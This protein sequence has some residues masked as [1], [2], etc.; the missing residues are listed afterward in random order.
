M[1][2]KNLADDVSVASEDSIR[3]LVRKRA[4][5]KRKITMAL[6]SID[7]DTT[8]LNVNTCKL[9]IEELFKHLV[10]LNDQINDVYLDGE[11]G[12]D[13]EEISD[14][15]S[16][17]LES[18]MNYS[19][20][21]KRKLAN[22][23][24]QYAVNGPV[25]GN[26]QLGAMNDCKLKLPD[27][28]I[29]S[30]NGEG[31]SNMEYHSFITSF[32]NI[33]GLRP[34][35]SDS[36]KF[37]YLKTYVKGYASKIIQ[38]LQTT[39]D[40]Y[41]VALQLLE[42][43][44]LNKEALISDLFNKLIELKPESDKDFIKTK[45]FIN[46]IKCVLSDLKNYGCD[47]VTDE[48]SKS[49][50]SHLVFSRLPFAF[51]QELVR[52]INNNYPSIEDMYD[53]YVEVVKTLNLKFANKSFERTHVPSKPDKDRYAHKS[54][55]DSNNR[56][57]FPQHSINA[58]S[59]S[60]S[61]NNSKPEFKKNCKFCNC[62]SHNMFNCKKFTSHDARL[63]RCRELN[64]CENCTSLKHNKSN[65]KTSLDFGC[66][67]CKSKSHISALCPTF[68]NKTVSN[69]CVNSSRL[70]GINILPTLNI[71]LSIGNNETTVR[72]LVDTGSQ[73]SYISGS[74]ADRLKYNSQ[75][76]TEFMVNTFLDKSF[77]TFSETSLSLSYGNEDPII[78]PFLV[79][80][81][82]DLSFSV[83]GLA[84][85][86]YNIARQYNLSEKLEDD[87]VLVEGVLGTDIIQ[88]LGK[89]EIV[90]CLGGIALKFSNGIVPIGN[91]D[92]FLFNKQLAYKYNNPPIHG[93][94]S[95]NVNATIVNF[96]VEPVKT[97]FDP[98]GCAIMDS[99]VDDRLDNLFKV[100]SLGISEVSCDYDHD[101]ITKF[102]DNISFNGDNYS[103]NLPWHD[104]LL[105][106]VP[107]N[108]SICKSVLNKVVSGLKEKNLYD[109]YDQVFKDQLENDIIE[110]VS[111]DSIDFDK[112]TFIPHRAVIKTDDKCTT[113]LRVVLNC[114]LKIGDKPS[115]NEAAY[116]GVNLMGDLFKLLI[117]VRADDY[118]VISDVKSAFLMIKLQK[119]SDRNHFT[120]LWRNHEGDLVA[121][122][123]KTIVFG[124]V[125][126][127]FILNYL[128][129]FHNAKY[130]PDECSEI[131]D[132]N[133]YVDNLFFTGNEEHM[134]ESMYLKSLYRMKQGGFELR[135]WA[136]NCTQLTDKFI[137]DCNHS[138]NANNLENLLGYEY[139]TS[140]DTINVSAKE[141]FEPSK[142]NLIT[143][144]HVLSCVSQVFDPL[145]LT[146]PITVRAKNLMRNI[147]LGK[148]DWDEEISEE[149]RNDWF[150]LEKDILKL[151]DI[152]FDR[153]AFTGDIISVIFFSDASKH[154]YGFTCYIKF[155]Q[156]DMYHTKLLFAKCK[157]APSKSKSL[158]TLELLGV[159]LA[160]KCMNEIL[161]A[162]SAHKIHEVVFAVDAQVVLS[163]LLT[164]NVK[165]KNVFAANRVKDIRSMKSNTE[166]EHNFPISFRYVPTD[167]NPAD[168]LT[169]GL[170]LGEFNS[171]MSFW[172]EGPSFIQGET[173]SWPD[174][175]LGCLSQ[176]SK[177]LVCN[178]TITKSNDEPILPVNKFSNFDKL[179]RVT[180]IVFKFRDSLLK[181]SQSDFDYN[182]EAKVYWLKFQQAEAFND[183][184]ICLKNKSE[185]PTSRVINLNLFLDEN[186]LL[187]SRGRL[188][189][190]EYYDHNVLNPILLSKN[191]F[192]TE[193]LIMKAHCKVKH[194]GNSTTLTCLR[195]Q[196]FWI[197]QGRSV[198][199]RVLRSC[200]LCKRV[201]ALPFK[202]PNPA[203]LPKER[204]NFVK[205]Y[206]H[207]GIDYTG[208]VFV[209]F[210]NEV[211][212]MYLL[213]FTCLNIR[214]VHIELLP[215]MSC[216][217]FLQAFIRFCNK[218]TIPK[219]V[220]SDNASVFI[221]G[222]GILS[223]FHT[224]NIF[225][226]Y[227]LNNN[228]KHVTIPLYSAWV[229]ATWERLIRTIKAS[230]QKIVGRKRMEYF[231]FLTIISE[232]EQA[233]NSRPLTYRSNDD[234]LDVISPNSFLKFETGRSLVAEGLAGTEILLP[235][236]KNIVDS[237]VK[238]EEMADDFKKLWFEEYLLSLKSSKSNQD[239]T[240]RIKIGDIVLINL[241][242]KPRPYYKL[243]R[244]NKVLTGTDNVIRFV[245]VKDERGIGVH[246]INHLYPLEISVDI[247][248]EVLEPNSPSKSQENIR[249]IR[250][251]ALRCLDR[252][253]K[254]N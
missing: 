6:N 82:F 218:Y 143:K 165:A 9:S 254:C 166:A 159:F 99:S 189:K 234:L 137:D 155:K 19:L 114:S 89:M 193:L 180:A 87:H 191:N 98:I 39:D 185:N 86:H 111:L 240:N 182:N 32:N 64:L 25:D 225:R 78:V 251:A 227:C 57:H 122:R 3:S 163:W 103:V 162:L 186:G 130:P 24:N 138:N 233:V 38:H 34:N 154:A 133:V 46:D 188:E 175:R 169:K 52:R 221:K 215:S 150:K 106:N 20:D 81:K 135:S 177:L 157:T 183:E 149:L 148:T 22:L 210:C 173:I 134:L 108:F 220:Y 55:D 200:T 235:N 172:C 113:K 18:Q 164:G 115:I 33:V 88:H 59:N 160:F 31:T 168:L 231:S 95:D 238:R 58:S 197:P 124:F 40:N 181:R 243:G 66:Y 117:K 92:N 212:K 15:Y 42:K 37:T 62:T 239:W 79:D 195:K 128:I 176:H 147:W 253:R 16:R 43:E 248:D 199:K 68:V 67:L 229:G 110:P 13:P 61:N 91:V 203:D 224:D 28:K 44:F 2:Q 48:S 14:E 242:N 4:V 223:E 236:R 226:E 101:K 201:N 118:L 167:F 126:S 90:P 45:I 144:R 174:N 36:T 140:T 56:P 76:K 65:C 250:Q 207:T 211:I 63:R 10:C 27:L 132:S 206:E 249:P 145:G 74:V 119:E 214:S 247:A 139:C 190:C 217:D 202:Y 53:N 129:K 23:N 179:V 121:Y 123:Y 153:K 246:S 116:P 69:F 196:G 152:K 49:F 216:E 131:L 1:S 71:N 35:L 213:I 17:E 245:E 136:S 184:L 171:N 146:L 187:R 204:V 73:R 237:L 142:G 102:A 60:Y 94:G 205:P 141:K 244:I 252:L 109:Q 222:L 51:R 7:K 219:V 75:N 12:E 232:I 11:E 112:Y 127:P 72:C 8:N 85:A 151:S 230:I 107:N 29:D 104:H 41:V 209:K 47:L 26:Q 161:S 125:S 77:R 194:L 84:A 30:F 105:E 178:A 208:H 80:K 83:D 170:T 96:I 198:V 50:I 70:G 5:F 93:D 228:I 97:G 54:R 192:I 156:N 241:P 120:V 158:P 21:I 100:E